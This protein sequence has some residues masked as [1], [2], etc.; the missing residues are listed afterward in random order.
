VNAI[1]NESKIEAI[2]HCKSERVRILKELR[3]LQDIQINKPEN[4]T[5]EMYTK[6]VSLRR[7]IIE[8][9]KT[10]RSLNEALNA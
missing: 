2:K 7:E 10:E 8:C 3:E 1:K 9:R 4:F 6:I 5:E